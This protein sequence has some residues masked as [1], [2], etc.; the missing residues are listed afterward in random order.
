MLPDGRVLYIGGFYWDGEVAVAAPAEVWDPAT[1]TLIPAGEL[2]RARV[3]HTS[4]LLPSGRVLVVGGE[5]LGEHGGGGPELPSA[6]LWDPATASFSPA[7]SLADPR[8]NHTATLLSDGRVLVVG[9][10][11]DGEGELEDGSFGCCVAH[12]LTTAEV[13][14]PATE[15]FSATGSLA[16]GR[17]SHTAT[18]LPD[19][20]V[21]VAGGGGDDPSGIEIWDPTT[22][23]F[24]PSTPLS[25]A[26]AR[27]TV[28]LL[29]DGRLLVIGGWGE[30]RTTSVEMRS[31]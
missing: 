26:R 12:A 2:G 20:R 17:I 23:A 15:S 27:H 30:G 28:T 25:E 22:G 6:E 16:G 7:G 11:L 31:P 14:D 29:P 13:W 10:R 9:G 5:R 24:E 3:A 1:E 18:H 19:G 21:L 8:Y 4:T